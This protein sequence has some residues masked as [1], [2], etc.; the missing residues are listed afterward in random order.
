MFYYKWREE[1]NYKTL[2]FSELLQKMKIEFQKALKR[3]SDEAVLKLKS[4]EAFEKI[5]D[6]QAAAILLLAEL[7]G[8]ASVGTALKENVKEKN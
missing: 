6:G 5:A 1:I 8:I 4:L 7:Q 3:L 2:D